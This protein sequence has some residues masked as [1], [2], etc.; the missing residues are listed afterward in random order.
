MERRAKR[1]WAWAGAALIA[2]AVGRGAVQ[3]TSRP[4]EADNAVPTPLVT[5]QTITP[6]GEQSEVGSHPAALA[7]TPDGRHLIVTTTGY[8]QYLSVLSVETGRQVSRLEFAQNR[9]DGSNK[10]EGLYYGLAVSPGTSGETNVFASRGAEDRVSVHSVTSDGVI[11][12]ASRY[13]SD[14]SVAPGPAFPRHTAGLAI[15]ESGDRIYCVNNNTGRPTGMMGSLTAFDAA[16]GRVVGRSRLPGFPYAIAAVTAGPSRGRKL[17]VSSERDAC[18]AV[19]DPDALDADSDPRTI[20]TGVHPI[21]L[22]L[23]RKQDRLFVANAGSDTISVVDTRTDRVLRSFLVRPAE[24]HGLPGATPSSLALSPDE[25]RLYVTLSDMNAVAVL[26]AGDGDLLGFI[27]VGWYPTAVVVA[28][29]GKRLFVANARGVKQ[30]HPNP[31]GNPAA[32][33]RSRYILNLAEGTVSTLAIPARRELSRMTLQVLANNRLAERRVP[34]WKNPGIEHIFYILKENRTYDQILGDLP[35][36]NGDPKLCFFPRPVTPNQHA[37]AERF[38]LLDNYYCC[39]DVSADG[40]NWSVSGMISEYNARNGPYGYSGRGRSYD[41]EG[42]NNGV[43]VDLVGIPDVNTAPAGYIWDHLLKAGIE[44]RNYGFYTVNTLNDAGLPQG[45]EFS[46][47]N[48][49]TKKSLMGRTNLDFLQFDMSYADSGAF[50]AYGFSAPQQKKT[51]GRFNSVSRY[52][53]WKREFDGYVRRGDLP[54]MQF[55]RLPRDH[56]QG[57]AVGHSS[58]RAM[59]A[60]NDYA[61]GQ[62]VEAISKS[63]YWKKCAIFIIE[64]DAQNGYDHVDAHRSV[65]FVISP[66]VR[67][68]TVDRRFYNTD[69]TLRTMLRLLGVPP[70]SRFDATA[71][72]LDVFGEDSANDAPYAAILPPREI[73]AEVNTAQ[74]YRAADSRR[75]DFS[76][77]DRVPDAELN[78]ILWHALKGKKSPAPAIRHGLS[79]YSRQERDRDD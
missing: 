38:V 33:D 62:L 71:P 41:Y 68:A 73:I 25:K 15:S 18:V 54:R 59:V 65:C 48:R 76:K 72:I 53:E 56:T 57:T 22:L 61:V 60:D 46:G 6:T 3:V 2:I 52:D 67:R 75:F 37:L 7:L 30:R 28:P 16:S 24:A 34:G 11:K 40:W 20:P 35:Q 23:N 50:T 19:L 31:T 58:P 32:S 9:T 63:P 43:P 26:D 45:S 13:L 51:Y 29:D 77:E 4:V 36:G 14:T 21:A 69:S 64:D 12:P 42:Q 55:I 17:Y 70:M 8:R 10:K 78:D 1:V 74:A 5:G 44:F 79:I 39:A 66:F 47:A 49:P 27:P